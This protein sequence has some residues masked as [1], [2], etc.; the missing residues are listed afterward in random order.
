MDPNDLPIVERPAA[1]ATAPSVRFGITVGKRNARRAVERSLVK[2]VLRE[3]A[4]Q[5]ASALDLAAGSRRV[6]VV[7]RL[8]APLPLADELPRSQLK[9]VLRA[10]AD[11]LLA[12]L[13]AFLRRDAGGA[14]A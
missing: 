9:R 4:R 14:P 7:I 1:S 10:E 2:R 6:D 12:Q 11:A 5:A 13:A 3:A 8:K